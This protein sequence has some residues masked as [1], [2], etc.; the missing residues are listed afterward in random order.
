MIEEDAKACYRAG[1]SE[2]DPTIAITVCA[3]WSCRVI[4]G[5]GIDKEWDEKV[6][7]ARG[8][9]DKMVQGYKG[10]YD[11]MVAAG[12]ADAAGPRNAPPPRV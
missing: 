9:P 8:A 6:F 5:H 1:W 2:Q 12:M 11:E 7:H 4:L 3:S 10:Y